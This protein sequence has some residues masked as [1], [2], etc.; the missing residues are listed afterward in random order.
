[1]EPHER[2]E[3]QQAGAVALEGGGEPDQHKSGGCT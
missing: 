2:I 3:D 1:V